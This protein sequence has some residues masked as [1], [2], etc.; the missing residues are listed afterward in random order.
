MPVVETKNIARLDAAQ[1]RLEA[2]LARI[3]AALERAPDAGGDSGLAE[4]LARAREDYAA[5]KASTDR[6]AARLDDTID[7][8][9]RL[10]GDAP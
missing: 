2:A 7:R 5:L 8:L 10:L 6:V 4:D 3:E 1:R 9:R